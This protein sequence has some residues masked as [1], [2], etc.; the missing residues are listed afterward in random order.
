MDKSVDVPA[1]A[2]LTPP[3]LGGFSPD[4][5]YSLRPRF[6]LASGIPRGLCSSC[7]ALTPYRGP[8]R[9]GARWPSMWQHHRP[10]KEQLSQLCALKGFALDTRSHPTA[11]LFRRRRGAACASLHG[12]CPIPRLLVSAFFKKKPQGIPRKA[13]GWRLRPPLQLVHTERSDCGQG[14][15][16]MNKGCCWT[17]PR[18]RGGV[19]RTSALWGSYECGKNDPRPFC[20]PC[21]R[22]SSSRPT[23]RIDVEKFVE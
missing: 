12:A 7:V 5:A 16:C 9:G 20:G 2:D 21:E 22:R 19:Y 17:I 6:A 1:S 14:G 15:L 18:A 13:W 23:H 3:P 8:Q 4:G 11:M 10:G